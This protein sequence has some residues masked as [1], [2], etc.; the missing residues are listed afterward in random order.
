[1]QLLKG[2]ENLAILAQLDIIDLALDGGY[3]L[4]RAFHAMCCAAYEADPAR[5]DEIVPEMI[6]NRAAVRGLVLDVDA[7]ELALAALEIGAAEA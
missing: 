6:V 7:D 5:F 2:D 3:S 4:N 1:M